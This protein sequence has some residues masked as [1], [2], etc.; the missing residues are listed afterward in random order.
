MDTMHQSE[1]MRFTKSIFFPYPN[2][3][4]PVI[5]ISSC[6]AEYYYFTRILAKEIQR[7]SL[8][9]M[10]T[11][12]NIRVISPLSICPYFLPLQK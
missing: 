2:S 11:S 4:S 5:N 12:E 6:K 9:Y 10:Y 7:E 8:S 3:T 1:N